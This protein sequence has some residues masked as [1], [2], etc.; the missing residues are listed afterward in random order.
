MLR[1]LPPTVTEAEL[2]AAVSAFH[3]EGVRLIRDRGFGFVE[4]SSIPEAEHFLKS[5][6]DTFMIQG[7]YIQLDFSHGG[8]HGNTG[9][10]LDWLCGHCGAHNFARRSQCFQCILPKD[11]TAKILK[12][13]Y[14]HQAEFKE[15]EP[16]PVL[17]V[18]GL[19][20]ESTSA[21][22][23]NIFQ[24][25]AEV[26][27]VRVMRDKGTSGGTARGFAFVQ[28]ATTEDAALALN[29]TKGTVIDGRSVRIS[30]SRDQ[31]KAAKAAWQDPKLWE[32][33]ANLSEAFKFDNK[34]GQYYDRSSGFYYDPASCLYYHGES[35]IYYRWDAIGLKYIQVDERGV[36]ISQSSSELNSTSQ[37]ADKSGGNT[38]QSQATN[39]KA[40]AETKK[41][42][43]KK[44]QKGPIAFSFTSSKK[45][46]GNKSK[47]Q[48]LNVQPPVKS[49]SNSVAEMAA[50]AARAAAAASAALAALK[51][52]PTAISTP[53]QSGVTPPWTSMASNE[54]KQSDPLP[55]DL[56]S[57]RTH[58]QVE[59]KICLLCKRKFPSSEKLFQHARMSA[60]HKKNLELLEIKRVADA[61]RI[62]RSK[63]PPRRI[64]RKSDD[65]GRRK[66]RQENSKPS[67][68]E[69][70]VSKAA[71]VK[72]PISDSN[73][74]SRMLKAMGWKKGE[75]L[76]KDS[77]G[78]TAPVQTEIHTRGAGLGSAPVGENA[79]LPGDSYQ[80]AGVKKARARY[81]RV[82][83][84]YS[85]SA[86]RRRPT[87]AANAYLAAM[88]EYKNSMCS[89][90][91][92]YARAMLK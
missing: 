86:S 69:E 64:L 82:S 88:N 24:P 34:T 42:K 76:G 32:R 72:K 13:S 84:N 90:K 56:Q 35:G 15:N 46:S 60:L 8:G 10:R 77:R 71:S 38:S 62:A 23:K 75:G 68:F 73:K 36:A 55:G 53:T 49:D 3:P 44:V 61:E 43:K 6:L 37:K 28:F 91:D 27:D 33:P 92:E 20:S 66:G 40:P 41:K 45:N 9:T 51:P 2:A 22:I 59:K 1:G 31:G 30:F 17:V 7:R 58:F 19:G 85:G 47:T 70:M 57:Q 87:D 63:P 74:G 52:E 4:F 12:D 25:H 29:R 89:E 65:R 5:N 54:K 26:L 21:T 18:L 11:E 16:N 48:G 67:A 80:D 81:E 79:V 50:A 83:H 14:Q 78:I 39:L